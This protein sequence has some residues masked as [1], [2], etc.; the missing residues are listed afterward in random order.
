MQQAHTGAIA[1]AAAILA[2]NL[3]NPHQPT[4]ILIIAGLGGLVGT[5]IGRIRRLSREHTRELAEDA[6][7][8]GGLIGTAVYL[9]ALATT[10]A[11][12]LH[13]TRRTASALLAAM[14][15]IAVIARSLT[16]RRR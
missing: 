3:P 11:G 7:F 13:W 6:S 12:S 5:T 2:A 16:T 10:I 9:A 8:A 14:L 15:L 1:L 4:I